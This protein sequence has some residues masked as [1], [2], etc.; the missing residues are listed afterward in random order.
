MNDGPNVADE[1][2]LQKK[3]GKSENEGH[4]VEV[5]ACAGRNHGADSSQTW[6]AVDDEADDSRALHHDDKG[7]LACSFHLFSSVIGHLELLL[8][9]Y[10]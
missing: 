10:N 5:F 7:G 3:L 2:E 9:V 1:D 4:H 6:D 8:F